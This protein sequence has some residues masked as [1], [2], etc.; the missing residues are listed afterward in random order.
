MVLQNRQGL[1]LAFLKEGGVCAAL[2]EKCCVFKDETGLVWDS[3]KRVEES[4]EER[5]RE[6]DHSESWY[7]NWFSDTPW[8][9][10]LLPAF[11]GPF[12]GLML[13][14]S[15][16]PWAFRRLTSFVKSQ[17][18]EATGKHPTVMYQRLAT[19]DAPAPPPQLLQF[20]VFEEL[21]KKPPSLRSRCATAWR[22]LKNCCQ[23]RKKMAARATVR[24]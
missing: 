18:D 12:I 1:N 11:L 7:K 14:L 4:L 9:S 10:T 5:R 19:N 15:F 23:R 3:I 2:K 8:V 17:I 24:C 16:G 6:I 13:L 22:R 21:S 20:E